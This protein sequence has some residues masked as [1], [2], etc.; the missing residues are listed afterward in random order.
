LWA[1]SSDPYRRNNEHVRVTFRFA[2]KS[3]GLTLLGTITIPAAG[4]LY[5]V[6]FSSNPTDLPLTSFLGADTNMLVTFLFIGTNNEREIAS[7][8]HEMFAAPT[9]TLPNTVV[10]ARNS[11][12]E[13]NPANGERVSQDVVLSW[14]PGVYADKHDV[15]FG[16]VFDNVNDSNRANPLEILVSQGQNANTYDPNSLIEVAVEDADSTVKVFELPDNP[17]AVLAADWQQ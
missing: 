2:D 3:L 16:T 15:Y 4:D 13:P 6:R 11:V 14:M 9:L 17:S 5:P 7:K 10:V 1:S 12:A 8:E